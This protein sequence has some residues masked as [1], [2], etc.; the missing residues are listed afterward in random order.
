MG[1]FTPI[2]FSSQK[3]I[4]VSSCISQLGH[5]LFLVRKEARRSNF[6]S[7][8]AQVMFD[9]RH[10]RILPAMAFDASLISLIPALLAV[11]ASKISSISQKKV[12]SSMPAKNSK[13][14]TRTGMRS[15]QIS[16]L[17]PSKSRFS[18]FFVKLCACVGH[19]FSWE[20]PSIMLRIVT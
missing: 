11:M 5:V 3:L 19:P 6:S 7:C 15:Y 8:S 12:A 1:L 16:K 2:E 20:R 17:S 10:N 14:A 4:I 13:K 9:L 18:P